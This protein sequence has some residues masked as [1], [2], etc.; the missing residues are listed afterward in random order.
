[1][2]LKKEEFSIFELQRMI[3]SKKVVIQD[4]MNLSDKE[5]HNSLLESFL[6]GV[7]QPL[8]GVQ[9]KDATRNILST[10]FNHILYFLNGNI[11]FK[12]KHFTDGLPLDINQ[13]SDEVKD[14]FMRTKVPVFTF[15][16]SIDSE[17][18]CDFFKKKYTIEEIENFK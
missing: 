7:P 5:F 1:M 9:S 17:F 13:I 16:R 8:L 3:E 10:D 4:T 14:R 2:K 15:A 18:I 6:M 12:S 11:N